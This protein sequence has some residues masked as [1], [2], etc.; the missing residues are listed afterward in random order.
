M[1]SKLVKFGFVAAALTATAFAG[2]GDRDTIYSNKE[3]GPINLETSLFTPGTNYHVYPHTNVGADT[4]Y[5][6]LKGSVVVGPTC[7]LTVHPG[8]R[9]YG[10]FSTN[11]DAATG[12]SILIIAPNG[13]LMAEGTV[14]SPIV[15]TNLRDNDKDIGDLGPGARGLWGG[16]LWC[17][18]APV[19][20]GTQNYPEGLPAGLPGVYY[21]GNRPHY[22]GGKMKYVSI[23]HGGTAVASNSETNGLSLY[24]MGDS[25][26]V[27][28]VEV[29]AN[30]DDGMEIFGGTVNTNHMAMIFN[31]DDQFD[32]DD[33]YTGKNQFWFGIEQE[34]DGDNG[35][36]MDGKHLPS[37]TL[38]SA[39]TIF[40]YTF[41]GS[42]K[43][44]AKP[45]AY[46]G[47]ALRDS[48]GGYICNGIIT[49]FNGGHVIRRHAHEGMMPRDLG[50]GLE[51]KGNIVWNCGNSDTGFNS[52]HVTPA[53]DIPYVAQYNQ[54]IDPSLLG[55]SHYD[56]WSIDPRPGFGS[57]AYGFSKKQ[58]EPAGLVSVPYVGAFDS[59]NLW[60]AG[61]TAAH[62]LNYLTSAKCPKVIRISCNFA[63]CSK[64]ASANIPMPLEF[65]I[66]IPAAMAGT[67]PTVTTPK[68]IID[69]VDMTAPFLTLG[70]V[71]LT[72]NTPCA[73]Y[74]IY[75]VTLPSA[76]VMV[77]T[78]LG[79]FV[80]PV[81]GPHTIR[82]VWTLSN[83]QTYEYSTSVTLY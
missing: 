16:I 73:K 38:C 4:A 18:E 29:F 26:E 71:V 37:D 49:D 81:K 31:S 79:R 53:T 57:A 5:Y 69:G 70:P 24:G 25:T 60:I 64:Y 41:I 22:Y 50:N 28:Y 78:K 3:G 20:S 39:P 82:L 68:I 46:R 61:W 35:G 59:T 83:T 12:T 45:A 77:P 76:T 52:S 33:G 14:D 6:F 34:Y 27:S 48:M 42:G 10:N 19:V 21:G 47:L 63:P 40:N 7:T 30:S 51:F 1:F 65:I 74:R 62:Q 56:N 2:S 23:R 32:I 55:V 58:A 80:R 75:R 8:A 15:F 67:V 36:E 54:V 72:S 43:Y 9:I 66:E 44:A 17:G 13:I 11:K